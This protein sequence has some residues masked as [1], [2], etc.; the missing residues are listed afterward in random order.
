MR[1]AKLVREIG[2][3]SSRE[4]LVMMLLCEHPSSVHTVGEGEGCLNNFHIPL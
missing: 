1:F 2:N 3:L 4:N